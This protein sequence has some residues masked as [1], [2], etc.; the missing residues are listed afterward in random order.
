MTKHIKFI[1]GWI[2]WSLIIAALWVAFVATQP[3]GASVEKQGKFGK[4]TGPGAAAEAPAWW[5]GWR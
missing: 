3:A 5:E 4:E 2:V 1:A